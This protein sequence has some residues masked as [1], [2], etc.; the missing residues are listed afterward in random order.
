MQAC[1][2][3]APRIVERATVECIWPPEMDNA[4]NKSRYTRLAISD[5]M[6]R[7]KI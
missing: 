3:Y 5:R 6:K 4:E 1:A 7:L 2:P